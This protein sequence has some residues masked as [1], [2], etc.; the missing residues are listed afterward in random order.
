MNSIQVWDAEKFQKNIGSLILKFNSLFLKDISP[1]ISNPNGNR[2][3]SLKAIIA[4]DVPLIQSKLHNVLDEI[5]REIRD[6]A[7]LLLNNSGFSEIESQSYLSN[8][9]C[10]GFIKS[11][12]IVELNST[13]G[14]LKEL[15]A[16]AV[17][18]LNVLETNSGFRGMLRGLYKGYSSPAD[19]ISHVFGQGSMQIEVNSSTQG[20]NS[21][22][23]LVGQ[24]I[25]STSNLLHQVILQKWNSFGAMVESL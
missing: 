20:F 5:E 3:V 23:L 8:D 13:L 16:I 11:N 9:F 6:S 17:V 24:S 2:K 21:A 4:L 18:H 22:A 25:D 15:S 14:L 19:G 12:M 10:S 1:V 7:S